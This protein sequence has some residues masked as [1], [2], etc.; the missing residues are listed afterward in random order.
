MTALP[1]PDGITNDPTWLIQAIDPNARLARL[2]RMDGAAYRAASFLDDR[3]LAEQRESRL[4]SLDELLAASAGLAGPPTNWIFHIGHVGSTLVSRLVGELDGVL[5]LREPRALRDLAVATESERPRLAGALSRMMT[6][7]GADDRIVIVKATSFVSEYAPMLAGPSAALLFLYATP[8][9]YVAGILAGENSVKELAALHEL[10][11][12]RLASRGIALPGFDRTDAHR[13]AAAWACEM[14]SLEVASDAMPNIKILWADF[15]A[16]L[17][18][19]QGWLAR[20]IAH[21]GI[22]A[23]PEQIEQLISSSLLRRYSKALEYDYS[24]ALRAEL[25]AEAS[26]D[27]MPDIDAALAELREAAK[28]APLLERALAR[29][30]KEK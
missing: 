16:M 10:R 2:V 17:G 28:A 4:C 8:S 5:A 12:Q 30:D 11:A 26:R 23:S 20:V 21:F 13:T 15:D 24:P 29:A 9:N 1:L 18:D 19:M 6:R 14:T 3:L 7:R 27:H 22:A 25:L